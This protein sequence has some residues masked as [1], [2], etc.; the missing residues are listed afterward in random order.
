MACLTS[1]SFRLLR[2]TRFLSHCAAV[3]RGGSQRAPEVLERELVAVLRPRAAEHPGGAADHRSAHAQGYDSSAGTMLL[4]TR[5]LS[6]RASRVSQLRVGRALWGC[7]TGFSLACGAFCPRFS[8]T[9]GAV[10]SCA[11]YRLEGRSCRRKRGKRRQSLNRYIVRSASSHGVVQHATHT[12]STASASA[13]VSISCAKLC[14]E[15][16]ER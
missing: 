6:R 16:S 14:V 12:D 7:C 2:R 11:R 4:S 1:T 3:P 8:T 5:R 9:H 13:S 15:A 10:G